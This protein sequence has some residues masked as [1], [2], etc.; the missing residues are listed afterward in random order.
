MKSTSIECPVCHSTEVHACGKRY[1][2]YPVGPLAIFGITFAALHQ[3]SA[4]FDYRCQACGKSFIR[5]TPI[6]RLMRWLFLPWLWLLVIALS[7][8]LLLLIL[9][10]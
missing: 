2:L 1:V 7:R 6:A 5:R 10:R 4:P 8:V 9:R 3:A